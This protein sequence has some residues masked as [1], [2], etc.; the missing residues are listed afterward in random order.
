MAHW[1]CIREPWNTCVAIDEFGP[2]TLDGNPGD[3]SSYDACG[4]AVIENVAANYERRLPN[5]SNIGH[6]RA[7]MISNG[8]WTS[9]ATVTN[10]R[11]NGCYIADVAWEIPRRKYAVVAFHD[12]QDA[13]LTEAQLLEAVGH[14]Q[15]AIFI[16]TNAQALAGNETGVHGHFVAVVGWDEAA[17][18]LYVL[19]SDIAGQ[20]GTASG[21]WTPVAQ[22]LEAQPHGYVVMAPPPPPPPPPSDPHR[23][24]IEIDLETLQQAVQKAVADALQNLQGV[25]G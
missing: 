13:V 1:Y 10:P 4:A 18:K 22:F 17:E 23:Q 8:K 20:H 9:G 24:K 16:L 7:D 6:I 5:Y 21:Q 19:N 11:T 14:E 2:G 12:Y 15:A 25:S 3:G